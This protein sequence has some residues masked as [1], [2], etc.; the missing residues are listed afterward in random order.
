M[1][2]LREFPKVMMRVSVAMGRREYSAA[3]KVLHDHVTRHPRDT[4]SLGLLAECYRLAG[5]D[6]SAIEVA[7]RTLAIDPV[8][9]GALRL[10]STIHAARGEHDRAAGYVRRG[11][12]CYPKD[13]APVSPVLVKFAKVLMRI[14][15]P[16]R[17]MPADA[18][19]PWDRVNSENREWFDWAKQY[20]A[21]FDSNTGS[22]SS[23]VLH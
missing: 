6:N 10:L 17:L 11:M 13:M 20:L 22:N 19:A 16:K 5:S 1:K 21:W 14:L 18:F 8:D 23:P 2:H 7:E 9:F 3:I 12:E 15:S 4:S